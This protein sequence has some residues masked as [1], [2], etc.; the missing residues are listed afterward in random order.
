MRECKGLQM[1]DYY[2]SALYKDAPLETFNFTSGWEP[3]AIFIDLGTNDANTIARMGQTGAN[4]FVSETVTFMTNATQYYRK[5][6]IQFFLNAGPMENVTMTLTLEAI[7]QAQK[8][9]LR[10]TFVNMSTACECLSF[11]K[12]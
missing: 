10:A 11:S 7:A 3:D 2:M 5:S 9:G 1:P 4:L 6:D 12:E 8:I